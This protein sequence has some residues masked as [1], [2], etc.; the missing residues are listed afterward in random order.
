M[1]SGLRIGMLG[2]FAA[3]GVGL[4]ICLATSETLSVRPPLVAER[5]VAAAPSRTVEPT[6]SQRGSNAVR[7]KL[8]SRSNAAAGT[9]PAAHVELRQPLGI[10]S[11]NGMPQRN[12]I[13]ANMAFDLGVP[14]PPWLPGLGPALEIVAPP[15][16]LASV[17]SSAK[18][19]VSIGPALIGPVVKHSTPL[20]AAPASKT[21]ARPASTIVQ[22][23]ATEPAEDEPAP[24]VTQQIPAAGSPQ[25]RRQV[26]DELRQLLEAAQNK[27]GPESV[28][29]P[30]SGPGS[31]A[32]PSATAGG[33]ASAVPPVRAKPKIT[34]RRRRGRPHLAR[35]SRGRHSRRARNDQHGRAT[36]YPA[37]QQR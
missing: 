5:P 12:D 29:K 20:F 37:E 31:S 21:V 6:R 10:S 33:A 24:A 30:S 23:A 34:A 1:S 35:F 26:Q 17:D 22:C 28:E 18:H 19:R 27:T 3:A 11:S 4:A 15:K 7:S 9:V 16:R 14:E 2:V 13:Q 25:V 32:R 36:E 8:V